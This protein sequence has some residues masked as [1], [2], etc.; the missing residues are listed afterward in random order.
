M[1]T[2]DPIFDSQFRLDR[3]GREP[4]LLYGQLSRRDAGSVFIP[5]PPDQETDLTDGT[6]TSTRAGRRYRVL[7][8]RWPKEV[9]FVTGTRAIA[10]W[11]VEELTGPDE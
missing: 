10:E 11:K 2:I 7:G 5:L 3:P 6:L 8:P 1:S 4:H 9:H